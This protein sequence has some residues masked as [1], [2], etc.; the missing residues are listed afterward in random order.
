M[1]KTLYCF[2]G[3]SLSSCCYSL[4]NEY[5]LIISIRPWHRLLYD[6]YFA[7]EKNYNKLWYPLGSYTI[8][9]YKTNFENYKIMFKNT[10]TK[11]THLNVS[12]FYKIHINHKTIKKLI[13]RQK[14]LNKGKTCNKCIHQYK[15][16]ITGECNKLFSPDIKI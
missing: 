10:N 9:L 1:K 12:N 6:D 15:Y 13:Q 14:Y 11:I 2:V 7:E 4:K 16:L 8:A 3:T 5:D